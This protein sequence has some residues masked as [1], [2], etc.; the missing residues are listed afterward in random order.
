MSLLVSK[1]S[2]ARQVDDG[3]RKAANMLAETSH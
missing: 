3:W 2:E 1:A